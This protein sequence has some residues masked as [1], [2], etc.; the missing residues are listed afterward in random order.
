MLFSVRVILGRV[1]FDHRVILGRVRFDYRMV[2][3][4]ERLVLSLTRSSYEPATMSVVPSVST[5]CEYV[6]P[7]SA[8]GCMIRR[9]FHSPL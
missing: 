9:E 8:A 2:R 1:R 7:R 3:K 5:R 4:A 6:M